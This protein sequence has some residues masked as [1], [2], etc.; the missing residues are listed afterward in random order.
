MLGHV[1]FVEEKVSG[2]MSWR[3]RRK[4]YPFGSGHTRWGCHVHLEEEEPT[5]SRLDVLQ[6]ERRIRDDAVRRFL[7]RDKVGR[8]AGDAAA[9]L[10]AAVL[11]KRAHEVEAGTAPHLHFQRDQ[12][13][14]E[15]Q[16]VILNSAFGVGQPGSSE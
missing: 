4:A 5:P 8:L 6:N 2:K 14:E 15:P 12:K 10:D 13:I 7:G 1:R 3:K 11:H 9:P 16:P